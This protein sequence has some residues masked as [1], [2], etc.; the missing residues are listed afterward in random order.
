MICQRPRAVLRNSPHSRSVDCQ[1][2][3]ALLCRPSWEPQKAFIWPNA[4]AGK[5]G[6]PETEWRSQT[7]AVSLQTS[8]LG[9]PGG[10]LH[11]CRLPSLRSRAQK[12][13][14]P[15]LGCMLRCKAGIP[16]LISKGNCTASQ[17][18]SQASRDRRGVSLEFVWNTC[19]ALGT[20]EGPP[21]YLKILSLGLFKIC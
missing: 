18:P 17:S 2:P 19:Y 11:A 16:T 3:A 1:A 7:S 15:P 21:V 10:G 5:Q 13:N 8:F 14:V 6:Q 12:G 4:A 20:V 9:L